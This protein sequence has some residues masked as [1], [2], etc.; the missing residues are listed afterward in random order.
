MTAR[1]QQLKNNLHYIIYCCYFLLLMIIKIFS[2]DL[3][4]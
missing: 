3:N 2:C 4:F 1:L